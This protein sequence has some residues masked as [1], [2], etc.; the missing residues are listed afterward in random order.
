[1][2]NWLIFLIVPLTWSCMR[3]EPR[4]P[5]Y[6]DQELAG[7]DPNQKARPK[8]GGASNRPITLSEQASKEQQHNP[9]AEQRSDGSNGSER[10]AAPADGL[11]GLPVDAESEAAKVQSSERSPVHGSGPSVRFVKAFE[12][13]IRTKPNR[14]SQIVGRLK[15][16]AQVRV[17]IHGGWSKLEDGQWVRTRWLVKSPPIELSNVPPDEEGRPTKKK[18][19]KLRQNK[20]SMRVQR[21]LKA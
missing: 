20:R 2:L 21:T 16:G 15:G 3:M 12:I 5:V 18:T 13:N 17:A 10:I 7:I 11:A 9:G 19:K 4:E 6:A 14:Y 8:A 1:M